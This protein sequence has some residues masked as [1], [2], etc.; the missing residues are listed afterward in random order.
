MVKTGP[1]PSAR[2]AA[3]RSSRFPLGFP[4]QEAG[5]LLQFSLDLLRAG[6]PRGGPVKT[7]AWSWLPFRRPAAPE[8]EC[9][10]PACLLYLL[11][12]VADGA[13]G[14]TR[15]Q[16]EAAFGLD[17][18]R[19]HQKMRDFLRKGAGGSLLAASLWYRADRLS[20]RRAYADRCQNDLRAGLFPVSV[21]DRAAGGQI[22]SWACQSTGGLVDKLSLDDMDFRTVLYMLG[23]AAFRGAWERPY[24]QK[25]IR[26]GVFTNITGRHRRVDLMHR[27]LKGYYE[28]AGLEGFSVPY[29]MEGQNCSF[30][31]LRP[32]DHSRDALDR[33]L[34]GLT[35]TALL[36]VLE[37]ENGAIVDS[38]LPRFQASGR[39]GKELVES[40]GIRDL[41]L[42]EQADLSLMTGTRV[43]ADRMRHEACI[44][45]DET[46]TVAVARSSAS[47]GLCTACPPC[48]ET[49][50]IWMDRPFL[51]LVWD[52]TSQTPLFLGAVRDLPGR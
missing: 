26:P 29:D 20:L 12:M 46:G 4:R 48:E 1:D 5:A 47:F 43:F 25:D 30:V 39:Y 34:A 35:G 23:V 8:N 14:E 16:M 27:E 38:A 18:D 22:E 33:C 19:L 50:T 36:E 15:R 40:L 10:S 45:V 11:G 6:Q 3:P 41:F 17:A 44:Q 7:P 13:A 37:W 42:R 2:R 31:A 49:R 32:I 9:L 24:R 28:G 21:F 51:Y 52:W